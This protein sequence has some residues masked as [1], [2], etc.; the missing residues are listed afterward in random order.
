LHALLCYGELLSQA[1]DAIGGILVFQKCA[2]LDPLN[3]LAYINTARTFNQ[4]GQSELATQHILHALSLDPSYC[5]SY[6]DL[7]QVYLQ[8][9]KTQLALELIDKALSVSRHVSEMRDV[10]T[11]QKVAVIQLKMEEKGLYRQQVIV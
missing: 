3:P 2:F 5:M 6:V 10:L 1:G 11:A 4:M 9:G 7:A 8:Q